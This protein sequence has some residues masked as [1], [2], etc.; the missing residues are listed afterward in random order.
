MMRAGVR[1]IVRSGAGMALVAAGAAVGIGLFAASVPDAALGTAL[2]PLVVVG[3]T[4]LLLR[5]V[6]AHG[7]AGFLVHLFHAGIALRVVAVAAQLAIGY[8]IYRGQVDFVGYW[9]HANTII[10]RVVTDL[11]FDRL[12]DPDFIS[13]YFNASSSLFVSI[14][15]ALTM[16]VVGPNIVALFL[17]CAPLSAA[18][19]YLFYRSFEGMAPDAQSRRRF[20]AMVFLFP[21]VAFWSVFLGKDVW[22]FFF[23]GCATFAAARVFER[24][25][26]GRVL[27]LAFSVQMVLLLRAHVGATLL[28]ALVTAFL[29][30]PL[31]LHGPAV[32]LR[33]V[34]RI[35]V[36]GAIV[37]AFTAVAASALLTVGVASL[38][39]DALAERAYLAHTGFATTEGGAALPRAIETGAPVDVAAFIPLGVG[40]LLFRPFVWEAHNALTLVAGLENLVFLGLVVLRARSIWQALRATAAS[41]MTVFVVVFFVTTAIVLSFDWNLGATLRHRTMVLPFLFM[42]LALPAKRPARDTAA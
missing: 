23:L 12:L 27:F 28:L 8:V 31:P 30:R 10:Y 36:S 40:T 18:A 2:S 14:I 17:V 6:A 20:G 1:G 26:P 9:E 34:V 38:S 3:L 7:D 35:V 41:S 13:E 11:R 33:P 16:M 22:V 25:R 15:L 5:R 24:A 32:Y 19:A 21:S 37:Y 4:V 42:M 39:I 29:F